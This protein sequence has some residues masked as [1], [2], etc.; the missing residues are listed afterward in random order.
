[1]E[2][3]NRSSTP[4]VSGI[5]ETALYV[6]NLAA[7]SR[8]YEEL[9]GFEMVFHNE[10]LVA[11][12]VAPSQILLLF[13][14]RASAELPTSAHDGSGRLHL[15]F[16]IDPAALATWEQRLTAQGIRL[17]ERRQWDRGGTSLYFRDPDGHLVELATPGV[18]SVY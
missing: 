2:D 18:W 3:H 15:A 6:A 5:L 17:E 11:L 14:K 12:H 1:M 4:P 8:F 13:L 10:R 16:A 7:S 9:F